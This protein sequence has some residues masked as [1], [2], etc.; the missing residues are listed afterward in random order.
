MPLET[1]SAWDSKRLQKEP[2]M[3]DAGKPL[4]SGRGAVT[5][6]AVHRRAVAELRRCERRAGEL[7]AFL[8]TFD[9]LRPAGRSSPRTSPIASADFERLLAEILRVAPRPLTRAELLVALN[10]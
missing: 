10:G 8:A 9:G 4:P 2:D 1:F 3:S 6:A 7:R 5:D